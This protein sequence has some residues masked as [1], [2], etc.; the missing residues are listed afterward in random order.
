MTDGDHEAIYLFKYL[1]KLLNG[2]KH[3]WKKL[4]QSIPS[5]ITS[6]EFSGLWI[7]IRPV[8]RQKFRQC[9]CYWIFN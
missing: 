3:F 1:R 6:A 2:L 9:K 5:P 4:K 8:D 7:F